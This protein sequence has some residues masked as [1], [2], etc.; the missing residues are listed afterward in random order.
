MEATVLNLYGVQAT[1]DQRQS[2]LNQIKE[3]HQL[4]LKQAL[5]QA[6]GD[7]QGMLKEVLT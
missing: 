6:M 7:I 2:M 5:E 1:D 4:H 3:V